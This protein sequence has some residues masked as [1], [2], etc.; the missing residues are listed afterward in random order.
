MRLYGALRQHGK[1][2]TASL[3]EAQ[4]GTGE[5][6]FEIDPRIRTL[7]DEATQLRLGVEGPPGSFV[8]FED[9]AFLPPEPRPN[10]RPRVRIQSG[11]K[12]IATVEL[13]PN[14]PDPFKPT[15]WRTK[16]LDFDKLVFDFQARGRYLPLV[17]LDNSHVN[18]DRPAFGLPSYVGGA[19]ENGGQE[20]VTCLGA[21]LGATLVGIDKARQDH[22]YVAMCEAWFNARNGLNLVLNLQRRRRGAR[23]GTRSGRVSSSPC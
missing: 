8:V 9:V 21:V 22:D 1:A 16:A 6:V 19:R 10:C 14:L 13:M 5:H 11:Q 4:D 15:N 2:L 12:D 23:S 7:S 18:F 3:A 17:W 20:G